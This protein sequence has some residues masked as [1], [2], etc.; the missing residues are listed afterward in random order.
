MLGRVI[1]YVTKV[2]APISRVLIDSSMV[3]IFLVTLFVVTDVFLRRVFDS[4]IRGS[5][6]YTSLAFTMIVFLP[7]AWCALR[8]GHIELDLI[9]KKLP[10][11]AQQSLE[12][13]MIFLTTG[14]L[15]LMSWRFAVLAIKFQD[16][17]AETAIHKIS[18]YPFTWIAAIGAI[19]LT[20]AFLLRFL[21]AINDLRGER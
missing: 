10:K 1:D 17:N 8:D 19:M 4:P 18:L 11:M 5:H 2:V 6:D 21:K 15:G 14:I 20:L 16:V 13:I 7:M 12:A 3:V 9:T